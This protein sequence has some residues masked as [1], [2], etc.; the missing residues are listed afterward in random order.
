MP[1]YPS[2]M[3]YW[4]EIHNTNDPKLKPVSNWADIGAKGEGPGF[5]VRTPYT[6]KGSQY[7]QSQ[8]PAPG[9]AAGIISG[10][11]AAGGA[12]RPGAPAQVMPDIDA[13]FGALVD[14]IK[15]NT[16][17]QK[18]TQEISD[19]EGMVQNIIKQM[20]E[21]TRKEMEETRKEEKIEKQYKKEFQPGFFGK[22]RER[23]EPRDVR[24]YKKIARQFP[25]GILSQEQQL[26]GLEQEREAVPP[27]R[28]A[29]GA[30]VKGFAGGMFGVGAQMVGGAGDYSQTNREVEARAAT[31]TLAE[32]AKWTTYG[33]A[34]AGGE[35]TALDIANDVKQGVKEAMTGAMRKFFDRIA[36]MKQDLNSTTNELAAA[37]VVIPPSIRDHLAQ[38][39]YQRQL[40]IAEDK[41]ANTKAIDNVTEGAFVK[42]IS[43]AKKAGEA[44]RHQIEQAKSAAMKPKDSKGNRVPT[45]GDAF[46][47]TGLLSGGT[48]WE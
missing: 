5:E 38:Q 29:F 12:G 42:V 44:K 27:A 30:A 4:A 21:E 20:H 47:P 16:E 46:N 39:S 35:F 6:G 25:G 8:L 31:G 10:A 14:A 18:E 23:F 22:M 26:K 43:Q 48:S 3:P 28:K 36:G 19:P 17:V 9:G 34:R 24:E 11:A 1:E 13:T 37:G 33:L 7:I 40:R 41:H 45:I 2:D 15:E 32:A